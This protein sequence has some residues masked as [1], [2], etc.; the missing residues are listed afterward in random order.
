MINLDRCHPF[1]VLILALIL[2]RILAGLFHRR[3]FLISVDRRVDLDL[4][5]LFIGLLKTLIIID[6]QNK[7]VIP[8]HYLVHVFVFTANLSSPRLII[9]VPRSLVFRVVTV[10]SPPPILSPLIIRGGSIAP[11][12]DT[13]SS[14]ALDVVMAVVLVVVMVAAGAPFPTGGRRRRGRGRGVGRFLK[15]VRFFT[16]RPVAV[17]VVPS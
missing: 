11:L 9:C 1:L 16:R 12:R 7:S 8:S 4:L 3:V 10:V 6:R 15:N 5:L 13:S 14:D 2:L 17:R